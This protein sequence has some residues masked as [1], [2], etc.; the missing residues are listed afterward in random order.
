LFFHR[1]ENN[2]DIERLKL[3]VEKMG[4]LASLSNVI[5][6]ILKIYSFDY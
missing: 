3:Y 5:Y 6:T 2:K 4:E 1:K